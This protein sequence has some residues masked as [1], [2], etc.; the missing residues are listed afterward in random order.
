MKYL[1]LCLGWLL[2][3]ALVAQ[4][5]DQFTDQLVSEDFDYPV[6]I[7]FDATGLGYVWEKGGR[8]WTVDADGHKAAEP[9]VDISEEVA[10]WR[11][12][13]LLGFALDPDFRQNG[14]LYLLYVVDLHYLN[15]YGTSTYHPDT[16]STYVASIG[17]ITRYTA[18][19]AT[20]FSSLLPDS[21]KIL[22]GE[23][24]LTGFSIV[25]ESHGVGTLA[26]GF[27]GTLLASCG[28]GNSNT[29][30]DTGGEAYGSYISQALADGVLEAHDDIGL[31]RAQSLLSHNGKILRLDPETGDGLASNPYYDPADPRSA[32]SRTWALGFRN[33]YRFTVR[34]NTGSHYPADG[35]PGTLYVGDVGD[36]AWEELNVVTEGGQNFG[37]PITEGYHHSY[38]MLSKTKPD[39]LLAPNPLY[40]TGGCEQEYFT[41]DN[42]FVQHLRPE[43]ASFPNP[44]DPTQEI[45]AS[46]FPQLETWPALAWSNARWNQPTRVEI[47]RISAQGDRERTLTHEPDSWLY[48]PAFDGFSSMAGVF[49]Q[50]DG[51]PEPYRDKYFHLDY[52]DWIRVFDFDDRDSIIA[53][54][55]FHSYARQI[56]HL[57]Q[58][59]TDGCLYYLNLSGKLRRICYGGNPPPVVTATADTTYGPGPLRVRFDASGTYSPFD[60]PLTYAWDFADGSTSSEIQPEHT[61]TAAS[62]APRVFPV[63][64]TVTDSVGSVASVEVPIYLNNT[65]PVIEE[66]SFEDGDRYPMDRSTIL[67]L[68]ARATDAEHADAQLRY[69]WRKYLHHNDHYHPEPVD[70]NDRSRL[71]VSPLGCDGEL[72]WYRVGLTV[73]DPLGLSTER[74]LE[75]FPNCQSVAATVG[76]L[77][78]TGSPG[79]VRLEWVVDRPDSVAGFEVL[80]SLD[81][82]DWERLDRQTALAGQNHYQYLDVAPRLGINYYRIKWRTADGRYDYTNLEQVAFPTRAA[83]YLYPNPATN[84]VSVHVER[85]DGVS[86]R[87]ELL[88]A[89]GQVL[90]DRTW[91]VSGT[92]SF[93]KSLALDPLATGAYFYRISSGDTEQTGTLLIR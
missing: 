12:H 30:P 52:S 56:Y 28:D 84:Q 76:P 90:I 38:S 86:V 59:P 5:P 2:S 63:R 58:H 6:G 36:V 92:D 73:T 91:T 3:G 68:N 85:P 41:Y 69:T 55:T 62:G 49:Y 22:L 57:A 74:T 61:F 15:H 24:K 64:L 23:S 21:R 1:F 46:A 40:G 16:T 82:L 14:R 89:I 48:S 87:L 31:F 13:G 8:V 78:A 32:R 50:G 79:E 10:N 71:V 29:G 43:D 54:D 18:D 88:N 44:C 72:Y 65:P 60:Y 93:D 47:G 33:P 80:R 26:F 17:R 7:T 81:L 37:W 34:P 66:I 20:G 42:T 11:D 75:I 19:P 25:H 51:F 70:T 27:D 67:R 45:P 35:Q 77:T 53:V 83:I 39:N 9:L 4:L